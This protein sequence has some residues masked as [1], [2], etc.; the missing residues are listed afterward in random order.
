MKQVV[1]AVSGGPV[2]V[3]DVPRPT[4]GATEVLVKT[5]ASVVSAGTEGALGAFARSNLIAKAKARPDLVKQ[6]LRKARTEGITS[7][8]R[9][10]RSRLDSDVPLGYSAVGHILEVGEAVTDLRPGMLVATAGAGKANHAE[11]QAVPGLLCAPVPDGVPPEDAAFA[12]LGAIALHGVRLSDTTLGSRVVIIGLGLLGQ[13]STRIAMAAGAEVAGIDIDD[14]AIERARGSGVTAFR[15]E[16]EQTTKAILE[17]TNGVGADA[18]VITASDS[19]SRIV[20][21]V[22]ELCRDKATVVVVGEV[23]LELARTPFYEKELQLRFARSYGPGRY[24]P[25]YEDMGVDYP[26]GYVRWTAGR[27]LGAVLDLLASGRLTVSDLVTHRLPVEDAASAYAMIE[28]RSEPFLAV[29]FTYSEQNDDREKISLKPS[30]RKDAGVG[31]IGAGSFA[32]TVLLPSVQAAGFDRLVSVAS[33]S[34]LSARS[35]GDGVGFEKVASG[36]DN[37]IDDPDVGVV[38][39]STPHESHAA[40]ATRALRAGKHVF[41]EKPLALTD[42]DLDEVEAAWLGS[43]KVLFVGFNRRWSKPIA[44]ACDAL[45]SRSAPLTI[46][47]RVNAQPVAKDHWYNDR[48]QGGRLLGEVCHFIDTCCHLVGADVTAV[49]ATAGGPGELI[50]SEH[51]AVNLGFADGSVASI[52]YTTGGHSSTEKERIE[53]L[54]GGRSITVVDF[55]EVIV[56]GKTTTLQ[57]MDKGHAAEVAAFRNAILQGESAWTK[58]LLE[59]SRVTLRAAGTL[60]RGADQDS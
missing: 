34:G 46:T 35:V 24:D 31:L 47:Y 53:I 25:F 20:Q 7:A 50:L 18:V 38:V 13:L 30:D 43:G 49:S 1:Q 27:N 51:L 14:A 39:I 8:A 10:V 40:L 33:A 3:V 2:R 54:G 26:I 32:R 11:F 6:V 58:A 22:P 16:G 15:E 9:A 17:W 29:E 59:S 55:R 56:D 12:T 36:A 57:R 60:G 48:R 4:I 52:T 41:C 42:E 37:V 28:K 21:R 45:A 19:S 44:M 23:G 5:V